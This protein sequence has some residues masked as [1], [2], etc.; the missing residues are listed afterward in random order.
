MRI[1]ADRHFYALFLS[2]APVGPLAGVL[3]A[4]RSYLTMF[5]L[6]T[7]TLWSGLLSSR[8]LTVSDP[9]LLPGDGDE[10]SFS[11]AALAAEDI[12][13]SPAFGGEHLVCA[14]DAAPDAATAA[15]GDSACGGAFGWIDLAVACP[16]VPAGV[17]G[18]ATMA[19]GLCVD[20]GQPPA[21]GFDSFDNL[22]SASSSS[23]SPLPS[24]SR[25]SFCRT[26]AVA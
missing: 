10:A 15:T 26:A 14:A 7:V 11:S 3:A 4:R 17:S 21:G 16:F 5:A 25:L 9:A 20:V 8:C 2:L 6:L 22:P 23:M 19:H 13:L 12:Y 18:N 24:S 1:S